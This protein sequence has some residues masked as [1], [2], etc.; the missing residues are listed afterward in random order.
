MTQPALSNGSVAAPR[1]LR[2]V[3]LGLSITSSWGNG[4]ATT[5]RGLMRAL[6]RRGHEVLFLE[7]DKPWYRAH[8][9][10][11]D[12][13]FGTVRLY[14]DFA[15]LRRRWAGEIRDADLVIVG[16]YVPDG[17]AIARWVRAVATGIVA[18]YDID[19]PVT[20]AALAD[21]TCP[22]LDADLVPSFDL[23]LS[24]TGGPALRLLETSYR[25]R[26]A[27]ALYC[28]VD[29]E[30]HRPFPAGEIRWE[31]GYLGTYSAD[32]Q[33]A[34]DAL[35]CEPAR[36]WKEGSF[37]VAGPLYPAELRW[38]AN[39]ERIEHIG[40][41]RHPRFYGRQLFTLNVTRADMVRLGYS[42]SVRLFEAAACGVP[43]ISDWWP[44]LTTIF[45]PG[46]EILTAR[47]GDEV[48]RFL[49]ETPEPERARIADAARARVLRQHTAEHRAA[50]LETHVAEVAE[51]AP[52]PGP[53]LAA[54]RG[55]AEVPR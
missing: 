4:H 26:A 41:D 35:L 37:A 49:R 30:R 5:Y 3:I 40:P 32:R 27:R 34:L 10:V 13:P 17:I 18:F 15:E 39:V 43:I 36:R 21:G 46:R 47:D 33:P 19:T 25:A 52:R 29:P 38:P 53:V 16:S 2:I 24:F 45:E 7:C 51:T 42:P 23:Y 48:L 50:E 8:R 31:L 28:S 1:P 55:L 14:E 54:A 9:D 6:C 22:Y 20:L 44:G 12:P 11:T